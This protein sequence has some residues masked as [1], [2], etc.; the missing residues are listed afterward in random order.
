MISSGQVSAVTQV[1][2]EKQTKHA[3]ETAKRAALRPEGGYVDLMNLTREDS[4]RMVLRRD[5]AR[6]GNSGEGDLP[7]DDREG[8]GNC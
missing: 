8:Q 6:T 2:A 7:K 5:R 3:S 4:R 1:G